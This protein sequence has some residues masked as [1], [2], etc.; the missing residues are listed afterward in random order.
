MKNILFITTGGT[1][2]SELTENGLTPGLT[3]DELLRYVPGLE[4]ICRIGCEQL[5]NL[6]S[7]DMTPSNWL[8]IAGAIEENY[9]R[10]DGFVV[11]HGTDTMAYTAAALSYLIQ[12]SPKPI[13]LT[14][15]QRPIAFDT[16]DSKVNL[17]DSFLCAAS[18]DLHGV[19]IVFSSRVILGTRACKTRT[20]SFEAFSSI[21]YPYIADVRDGTLIQYITPESYANPVFYNKLNPRVGL[22][23]LIPGTDRELLEFMLDRYDGLIIESFGVGGLPQHRG[24]HHAVEEAAK[25]GKVVVMTTQVQQE[26][27]DLAVYTTGSSLARLP[28][29]LEARDMTKEATLAKLMWIL[30]QTGDVT[31][32]RR[33]FY[34]T[35]ASDI[36]VKSGFRT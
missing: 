25:R 7:T 16:T 14:G 12:G 9:D 23:K 3:P 15:A 13:I 26:G 21:N 4:R 5:M 11:S 17:S 6:D 19:N 29:V 31:R 34:T 27:S 20:K 22:L 33:M 28:G 24:F 36:L 2:A 35:I 10:Y 32:I 18:D 30:A 8:S 1:I